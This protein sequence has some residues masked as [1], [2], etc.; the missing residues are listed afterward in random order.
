M[1]ENGNFFSQGLLLVSIY[2]SNTAVHE[3]IIHTFKFPSF[4]LTGC[5][6]AFILAWEDSKSH[7]VSMS[8]QGYVAAPP[9]SQAQPGMGGYQGGFGTGPA[10]PLYGHYGGPPQ[11]FTAPP[12]GTELL[13]L[14]LGCISSNMVVGFYLTSS[15]LPHSKIS[16]SI[17][18]TCQLKQHVLSLHN[19]N[20]DS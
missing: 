19:N 5:Q 2:K 13:L 14:Y 11:A 10:Q 18:E 3:D 8:Q 7:S 15:I 20:R 17:L 9:Y 16:L 12:T 1:L 6:H 4:N